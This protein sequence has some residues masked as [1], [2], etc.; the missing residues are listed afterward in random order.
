MV[1][2]V[3]QLQFLLFLLPILAIYS[4]FTIYPL[5]K[6]FFLSFTNFDGY[7]E[8]Y[9]FIGLKNYVRIFSDDAITSAISYTLFLL[10]ARLCLLR[11]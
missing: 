11:C 4:L 9:D 3:R 10:L 1:K 2:Y 8:A 7:T 6:S 5:I